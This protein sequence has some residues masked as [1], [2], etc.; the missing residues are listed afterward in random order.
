VESR[1]LASFIEGRKGGEEPKLSKGDE[2]WNIRVMDGVYEIDVASLMMKE[3][4]IVAGEEGEY[5]VSLSSAFEKKSTGLRKY[6]EFLR[7]K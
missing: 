5:V 4:I 3:P 2:I 6:V 1:E 7:R